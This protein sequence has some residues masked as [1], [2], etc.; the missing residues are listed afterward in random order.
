MLQ[1]TLLLCAIMGTT[2]WAPSEEAVIQR[3]DE[4]VMVSVQEVDTRRHKGSLLV[5]DVRASI[6]W[7]SPG[8]QLKP[9]QMITIEVLGGEAFGLV[10][11]VPGSFRALKGDRALVYL[12]RHG[13]TYR[14]WGLSYG[15]LPVVPGEDGKEWLQRSLVGLRIVG[16][17]PSSQVEEPWQTAPLSRQLSFISKLR[18]GHLQ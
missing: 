16:N 11:S 15:W 1:S 4:V 5:Q 8:G 2:I 12:S 9:G 10:S 3:A 18:A 7:S 13:T 6:S 17:G 14:P